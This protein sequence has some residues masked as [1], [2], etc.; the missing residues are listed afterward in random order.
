ME[1]FWKLGQWK[2]YSKE[3]RLWSRGEEMCRSR[4]S[5]SVKRLSLKGNRILE[6]SRK[7]AQKL[8]LSPD[9]VIHLRVKTC[10]LCV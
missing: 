3:H 1:R 2:A 9:S 4:L 7:A 6:S 5:L 10:D 8:K